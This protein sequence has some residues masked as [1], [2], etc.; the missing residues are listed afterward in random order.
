[1]GG[2]GKQTEAKLVDGWQRK[3]D[4][5]NLIF[6]S[7]LIFCPAFPRIYSIVIKIIEDGNKCCLL[8][9]PLFPETNGERVRAT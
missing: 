8:F 9:L 4:G 7:L 5:P 1:M 6:L 3:L 2:E